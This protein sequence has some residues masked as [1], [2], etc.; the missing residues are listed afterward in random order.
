LQVA[1]LVHVASASN[2]DVIRQ[3]LQWHDFE[4]RQQQL[5]TFR[6]VNDVIGGLAYLVIAF[7]GYRDYLAGARFYFLEV[8]Q[9]LLVAKHRSGI[10]AIARGDDH[11]RKVLINQRIGPMLHF[12]GR[13]AL[14]VDVR[15]F[16][17]L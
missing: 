8:R 1:R 5:R 14:G 3:Q 13:I 15:N 10:V 7:V 16:F 2:R 11:D 9:R 17:Q 12:A 6:H 4:D